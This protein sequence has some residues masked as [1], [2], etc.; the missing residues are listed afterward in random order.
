MGE[1]PRHVHMVG[2]ASLDLVLSTELLDRE[3]AFAAVG[4]QVPDKSLLVN[5]H[6]NTL[7]DTGVEL[8]ALADALKAIWRPNMKFIFIGPNADHG[9]QTIHEMF[10]L[11]SSMGVYKTNL[12]SKVCLSLMY[13]CNAMVGNSS[14]GLYEAPSF[15][16]PVVNIGDRQSGRLKAACITDCE[17]DT[18]DLIAAIRW[19]LTVS[20]FPPQN[21]YGDGNACKR[22]AKVLAGIDNPRALLHKVWYNVYQPFSADRRRVEWTNSKIQQTL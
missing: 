18:K 12:E 4:L 22:I 2:S 3:A 17:P 13:W 16:T 7:G 11:L 19:A 20:K 14:A 8:D 5:L 9:N 21:P 6:P 10:E 15:G 1:D